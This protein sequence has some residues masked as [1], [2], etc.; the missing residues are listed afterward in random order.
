M[1]AHLELA[2]VSLW[3]DALVHE[4]IHALLD[5]VEVMDPFYVDKQEVVKFSM[6]S[7]W[8]GRVLQALVSD[9]RLDRPASPAA[10][11]YR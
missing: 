10:E 3:G 1:N 5:M 8:S 2:T 6:T 11:P 7:P 4:A 9:N